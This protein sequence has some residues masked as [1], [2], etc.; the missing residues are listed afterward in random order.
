MWSNI[1]LCVLAVLFIQPVVK[2]E[3]SEELATD[4][5]ILNYALIL[6]HLEAT[7]YQQGVEMFSKS[8][9]KRYSR[10]LDIRDQE[11]IHV[12]TLTTVITAL[13]GSPVPACKYDFGYKTKAEFLDVALALE[14]VGVSAYTGAA[15]KITNG[16][17]LTAAASIVTV[18]ARHAA[19]LNSING[20]NPFPDAFDSPLDMRAVVGLAGAF[21][22]S[23]PFTIPVSPYPKLTLTSKKTVGGS[24][25]TL[26]T[27]KQPSGAAYC[28]FYSDSSSLAAL[29]TVSGNTVDCE[30]PAAANKGFNYLFLMSTQAY[31]LTND[32]GIISGP[33]LITV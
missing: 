10:I 6:E 16:S 7:F 18:E 26:N 33:V 21:I 15:Y 2:S 12:E 22:T 23:C 32:D 19:W 28:V 17:L 4:I 9:T 5:G 1:M 3:T 8:L 25:L 11:A 30:V 24:K 31:S 14:S 27:V 20:M 29:A 13:G